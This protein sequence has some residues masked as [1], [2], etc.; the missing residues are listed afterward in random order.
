MSAIRFKRIAALVLDSGASP[1][2]PFKVDLLKRHILFTLLRIPF[3]LA[4]VVARV[5]LPAAHRLQQSPFLPRTLQV[6][7]KRLSTSKMGCVV[8]VF[9]GWDAKFWL[10]LGSLGILQ[11]L[12]D[13]W[14]VGDFTSFVW[15]GGF[16]H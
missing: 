12:V 10:T 9:L 2:I 4:L 5:W 11:K 13:V 14:F 15:K 7:T 16:Y 3:F 8:V 1:N 6:V